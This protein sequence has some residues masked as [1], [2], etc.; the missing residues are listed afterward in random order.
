M[1]KAL[2]WV[3]AALGTLLAALALAMIVLLVRGPSQRPLS[4][5]AFAVSSQRLA[6]GDYLANHVMFCFACHSEIQADVWSRPP[7]PG[8]QG[9]GRC[10]RAG[11]NEPVDDVVCT[12][13]ITSD[14][15][16]GLG[17][18]ADAEILAAI[19]EGVAPG[20]RA[21]VPV[22]PYHSYRSLS[23]EDGEALI[24]YLRSL[25]RVQRSMRRPNIPVPIRSLLNIIPEPLP[26]RTADFD[27]NDSIAYGRYLSRIAG[28]H[29]CHTPVDWLHRPIA[30]L[31]FAG[32]QTFDETN[33]ANLTPHPS[34]LGT[35][36]KDEFIS[37]FAAY[38]SA[39]REQLT[40]GPSWNTP[41]PWLVFAGMTD[42]DLG[43]IYD[44][45]RTVPPIDHTV[46]KFANSASAP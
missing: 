40:V 12:P 39:D 38:R 20:G 28:C 44:Y 22:M 2:K 11:P 16:T 10:M 26:G 45:L 25:P 36:T 14:T 23:D 21:L 17:T 13:N 30:G 31:D 24:V 9:A 33:S 3:G 8:P 27:R 34:G 46:N 37:I 43:A 1:R 15:A 5:N 18:W 32:G 41:M 4:K 7:A 29:D 35:R 19:R 6:R 42:A